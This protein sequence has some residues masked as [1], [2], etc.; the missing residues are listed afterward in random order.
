MCVYV[1]HYLQPGR[2]SYQ[3]ACCIT[4]PVEA[5]PLSL[6]FGISWVLGDSL[7]SLIDFYY[8]YLYKYAY[9]H[10]CICSNNVT[11]GGNNFRSHT[12]YDLQIHVVKVNYIPVLFCWLRWFRTWP[13]VAPWRRLCRHW[14][15]SCR[16]TYTSRCR[17]DEC[18]RTLWWRRSRHICHQSANETCQWHCEMD[19]FRGQIKK[20]EILNIKR[21]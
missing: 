6:A 14:Y 18:S 10:K 15:G 19:L 12:E 9:I 16:Y 2:T 13:R 5:P 7:S 11:A 17:T 4:N 3:W 8:Y 1:L 21:A 20:S